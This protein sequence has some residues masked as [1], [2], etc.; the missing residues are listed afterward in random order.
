[1]N[2]LVQRT[3]GNLKGIFL[4][5]LEYIIGSLCLFNVQCPSLYE[6]A[7]D[8]LRNCFR[9]PETGEMSNLDFKGNKYSRSVP[10]ILNSL[11]WIGMF[12]HDLISTVFSKEFME[13]YYGR[14]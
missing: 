7:V 12:P 10:Q 5:D 13:L 14:I 11:T 6:E 2:A 8:E 1:M 9:C 3:Q 4:K